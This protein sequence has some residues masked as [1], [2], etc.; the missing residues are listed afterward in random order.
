MSKY[1]VVIIG[2]SQKIVSIRDELVIS[3]SKIIKIKNIVGLEG[4]EEE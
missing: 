1:A 2:T 3:S 4:S